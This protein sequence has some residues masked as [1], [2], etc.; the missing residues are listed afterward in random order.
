MA[1]CHSL[2]P[3]KGAKPG[4]ESQ[5]VGDPLDEAAFEYSGWKYNETARCYDAPCAENTTSTM[6]QTRLWQIKSFPFDPDKRISTALVVLEEGNG[7]HLRL[8]TLTKGSPD[9]MRDMYSRRE[10]ENFFGIYEKQR[11]DFEAKGYR[12]IAQG[13][14]D[15]TGTDDM[16][17]LF[18]DGL[19]V[20]E[21]NKARERAETLHRNEFEVRSLE[22]G[23]FVQFD[24]S[25]RPSSQR[26]IDELHEG[27]IRSIM[28]TGDAIDAAVTVASKVGLIRRRRV[29]ILEVGSGGALQWRFVDLKDR[30]HGHSEA[31]S[32]KSVQTFSSSIQDVL[33]REKAG[34]CAI[35]ATGAALD[36]V[37]ESTGDLDTQQFADNL[38]RVSVI[39]RATPKQKNEVISRLKRCGRT[40]MMCGKFSGA[41]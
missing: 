22:F 32:D 13:W 30:Q 9:T 4:T 27:G 40:V 41:C 26:I 16:N 12:S 18:P 20:T 21:I 34:K 29:A 5:L 14:K 2:I 11:K 39:A 1:G 28:L 36:V 25:I 38:A 8:L 33:R 17:R 24:A 10:E 7:S 35:A 31:Q 37:F 23:G 3:L 19:K 6:N 15:L